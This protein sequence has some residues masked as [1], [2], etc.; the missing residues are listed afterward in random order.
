MA[1][2]TFCWTRVTNKGKTQRLKSMV[3]TKQCAASAFRSFVR[4]GLNTRWF[5]M[6]HFR[7]DDALSL[8]PKHKRVFDRCIS[9]ATLQTRSPGNCKNLTIMAELHRP[10]IC[11]SGT[12]QALEWRSFVKSPMRPFKRECHLSGLIDEN[13]NATS[14]RRFAY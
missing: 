3:R 14:T 2:A 9:V 10:Q 6:G 11:R 12:T 7:N 8:L 13:N 4:R 1:P 5:I